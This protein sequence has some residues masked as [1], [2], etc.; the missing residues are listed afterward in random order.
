MGMSLLAIDS[1]AI[2]YG[3]GAVL[4]LVVLIIMFKY[5]GLFV[6]CMT[7]NA[8]IGLFELMMMSLRKVS[9]ETIAQAKISAV[10]AGLPIATRDLQAHYL[11]GGNVLNV[12]R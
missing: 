7:S 6:R 12:V 4:A 3:I 1:V 2:V 11:A 8:S 5:V 10:Q 9:P